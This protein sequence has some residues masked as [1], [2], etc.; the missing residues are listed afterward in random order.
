MLNLSNFFEKMKEDS[1]SQMVY[2]KIKQ[3]N[4]KVKPRFYFVLN[5]FFWFSIGF[6]SF[7][8]LTVSIFLFFYLAGELKTFF[9]IINNPFYF[10]ALIPFL[11]IFIGFFFLFLSFFF[12]RKARSCCRHENWVLISLLMIFALLLNLFFL[13]NKKFKEELLLINRKKNELNLISGEKYWQNPAMGTLSGIVLGQKLEKQEIIIRSID[14]EYWRVE[15]SKCR[16]NFK[17]I[18]KDN[19]IR[20]VGK[21]QGDYHFSAFYLWK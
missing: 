15:T 11:I 17:N 3:S 2:Q 12:Y 4:R 20:S 10:F 9:V 21:N 19:L 14:G 13:K 18:E 7:L 16:N 5:S 6:L 8:G 1:I